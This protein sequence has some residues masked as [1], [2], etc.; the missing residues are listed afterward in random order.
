MKNFILKLVLFSSLMFFQVSCEKE[1]IDTNLQS[2]T[3][4]SN[5]DDNLRVGPW[6]RVFTDNFNS[7]G[8]LNQWQ[9]TNRKDYN[10]NICNYVS[11]NPRLASLDNKQ[12]LELSAYKY[13]N[14]YRSG[15]VKSYWDFHPANNEEYHLTAS[16]KLIAKEGST[17]KGF[18]QTY[19]AWPAFWTVQETN[20]PTKGEIDILEG[21]SFGNSARF[22][23]NLFY[24]TSTGNNLLGNSAERSYSLNEGWHT[25]QQR[26]KNVNG[27]VTVEIWV[28]GTRRAQY[29]NAT[30]SQLRLQNFKDHNI[31]LNLNVGSNTGIFD[32]SRIN[33]FSRAY[34]YVDYVRVDKRTI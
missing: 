23:S 32:N 17:Y 20:W 27:T 2:D 26:W 8:N 12:C 19:G 25:Y 28:D 31:I 15:H 10:S 29:S 21:Y 6:Q 1:E 16:I 3:E 11:G 33:L 13:G 22:A 9:K 24:G 5:T 34:M 18:A 7:S 30:N 14:E 4:V